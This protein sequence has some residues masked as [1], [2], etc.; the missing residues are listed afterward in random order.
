[1]Q[2]R[3][4]IVLLTVLVA[5]AGG[6]A[7]AQACAPA[8]RWHEPATGKLIDAGRLMDMLAG[9]KVVL[10]GETHDDPEHHRWQ[11]H[12]IAALY[13]RDPNIVLGFEAF[14]HRVQGVLDRWVQGELSEAAFL[15]ET[16][17][18]RYWGYPA[19]FYMP[20]FH[21]ARQNR[22]PMVALNVSR[23]LVARIGDQG[24]DAIAESERQG[25][26]DPAPAGAAYRRRL[27]IVFAAHDQDR[28]VEPLPEEL[29][30][31]ETDPEFQYF[32]DAQL[33][34]E[35]AMA[36]AIR[37]ASRRPGAPTVVAIAGSGHMEYGDGIQGQLADL[38]IAD[39]AV[40]LPLT[41]GPDC[42]AP[43]ADLADAVFMLDAV[44][45][46]PPSGPRLGVAIEA[47][48][49][50]VRVVRVVP[51]SVAEAASLVVGDVIMEAAGQP[52]VNAGDL[53]R[54]VRRQA[55][56]TWLPLKV[57]RGAALVD[58]VAKF[59]SQAANDR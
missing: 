56:G 26:T 21:F 24:W 54:I 33:T 43:E 18:E 22:V 36:Q 38:G 23:A 52:L 12:T 50:G 53:V 59:P 25:V 32:V 41:S 34:W 7:A 8:G 47:A 30:R 1:M 2:A 44:A 46:P 58:L 27:A 11:L 28:T 5:I 48:D 39:V 55:P 57:R 37:D 15:A 29:A 13:G 10:L 14:P 35:R 19:A 3:A 40:L 42:T 49:G 31:I 51:D 17:W 45:S 9:R 20:L 16:D 6:D 4:T